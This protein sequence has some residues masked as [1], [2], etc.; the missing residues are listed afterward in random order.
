MLETLPIYVIRSTKNGFYFNFKVTICRV[1]TNSLKLKKL[2]VKK[3][4]MFYSFL[5]K[6]LKSFVE[7]TYQT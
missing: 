3:S 1:I 5:L 7:T 6:I 2:K 4:Q